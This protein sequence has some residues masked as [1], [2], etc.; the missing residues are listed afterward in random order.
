MNTGA[1]HESHEASH[2]SNYLINSGGRLPGTLLL[3]FRGIVCPVRTL[4]TT[5]DA[6][7][8]KRPP[9]RSPPSK[10]AHMKLDPVHGWG[11]FGLRGGGGGR[12]SPF[13]GPPV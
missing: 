13:P 3:P 6:V 8:R 1:R 7:T 5:A 12:S 4:C 11:K 9:Q 2:K 10:V